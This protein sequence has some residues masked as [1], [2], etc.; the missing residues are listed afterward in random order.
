M[1]I[2]GREKHNPKVFSYYIVTLLSKATQ[3]YSFDGKLFVLSRQVYCSCNS[4]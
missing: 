4:I 1:T 2:K 3:P